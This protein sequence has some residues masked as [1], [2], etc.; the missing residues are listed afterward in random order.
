MNFEP[1]PDPFTSPSGALTGQLVRSFVEDAIATR[2][3]AESL[4]LEFKS[5]RNGHNIARAVAAMANTDGGLVLVGVDE[6]VPDDPVVGIPATEVDHIVRQLRGLIPSAMPEVIPIALGNTDKVVLLLRVDADLAERPVVID[7]RVWKRV[8]GQTVGAR[9]DEIL[10]LVTARGHDAGPAGFLPMDPGNLRTW[11]SDATPGE[12]RI[13]SQVLLPRHVTSRAYLGTPALHA[14]VEALEAGPVPKLICAGQL[15]PHEL[16]SA[17]WE[18][19]ESTTLRA[20]FSCGARENRVRGVPRFEALAVLQ[21][22]GRVLETMIAVRQSD[23]DD[24]GSGLLTVECLADLLLSS[25]HLATALGAAVRSSIGATHP[26]GPPMLQGWMKG[27]VGRQMVELGRRWG[28]L[29]SDFADYRFASVRAAGGGLADLNGVV[30]LWL[31]SLL[32]DLG[33]VDVERELESLPH[34]HWVGEWTDS[35]SDLASWQEP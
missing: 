7:G 29:R 11:S 22:S 3:Q 19:E 13:H 18:R 26:V 16:G 24:A 33:A 35:S 21:L 9:R 17:V 8:P 32:F 20:R 14:A 23:G 15:R 5:A 25:C 28:P 1:M 30:E 34:P 4:V 6:D 31:A 2:L 27:P 10:E 12:L